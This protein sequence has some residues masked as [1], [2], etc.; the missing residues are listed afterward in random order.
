[1]EKII[2]EYKNKLD[3][4]KMDASDAVSY[5]HLLQIILNALLV[6]YPIMQEE[7]G[8][9]DEELDEY[10]PNEMCIRDSYKAVSAMSVGFFCWMV[11]VMIEQNETNIISVSYTHLYS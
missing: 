4:N 8:Y 9:E 1:M 5:T 2:E 10:M 3:S 6:E 11:W 7:Y